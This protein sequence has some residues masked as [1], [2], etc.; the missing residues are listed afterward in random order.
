MGNEGV[1]PPLHVGGVQE[2]LTAPPPAF[3]AVTTA[4]LPKT[5]LA[6][7]VATETEAG[8][9]ELQVR[10]IPVRGIPRMS[11]TFAL[12]V[13]DELVVTS[14]GVGGSPRA[15]IEMV[16]TGQVVNSSG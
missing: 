3:G 2:A 7:P 13:V 6:A 11:V 9:V 4:V 14:S 5:V 8:S 10:G 16:C 1:M 15:L 12:S